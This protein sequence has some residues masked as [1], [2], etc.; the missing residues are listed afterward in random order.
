MID[1]LFVRTQIIES[2]VAAAERDRISLYGIPGVSEEEMTTLVWALTKILS[3]T[4]QR[5]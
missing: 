1:E 5:S 2:R 3:S 4:I